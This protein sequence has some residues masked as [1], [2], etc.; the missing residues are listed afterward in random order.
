ML[1]HSWT[2]ILK[3]LRDVTL[4]YCEKYSKGIL[5]I[6]TLNTIKIIVGINS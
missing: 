3:L 4:V 5:V 1:L 6:E 2:I